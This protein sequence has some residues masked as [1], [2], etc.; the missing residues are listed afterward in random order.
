MLS[1]WKLMSALNN[2]G[3][4]KVLGLRAAFMP[5]KLAPHLGAI[6]V[7]G[8]PEEAALCAGRAFQRVWLRA[9]AF[10][11][12]LQPLA[13]SVVLP[14]QDSPFGVSVDAKR[15]LSAGWHRI[16]GKLPLMVFRLGYARAPT[17]VAGRP[18]IESAMVESSGSSR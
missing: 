16:F 9:T 17:L 1:N 4:Y 14:Y 12:A 2:V 10:G 3:V 6:I 11:M 13:A 5:C 18:S 8:E 7:D 15:E